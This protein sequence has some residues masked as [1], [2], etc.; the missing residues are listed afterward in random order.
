MLVVSPMDESGL[1]TFCTN[2][3]LYIDRIVSSLVRDLQLAMAEVKNKSLDAYYVGLSNSVESLSK[4]A[5]GD[6]AWEQ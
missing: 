3:P 4:E 5:I 6:L 1:S 2:V